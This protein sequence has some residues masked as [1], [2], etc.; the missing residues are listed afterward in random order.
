MIEFGDFQ[1]FQKNFLFSSKYLVQSKYEQMNAK[2]HMRHAYQKHLCI[3]LCIYAFKV[4]LRSLENN[5]IKSDKDKF[6][7]PVKNI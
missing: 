6:E 4:V 7:N 2:K 3:Y 1:T 5:Q